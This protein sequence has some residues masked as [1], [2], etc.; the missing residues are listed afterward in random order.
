MPGFAIA[1]AKALPHA[2][3]WARY[4]DPTARARVKQILDMSGPAPIA[5]NIS[6]LESS[7]T[8]TDAPVATGVTIIMPVYNNRTM[9]MEALRRVAAHTDVPWRLILIDDASP[10]PAVRPALGTFAKTHD[11]KVH[12]VL[13]DTNKGFVGTV[14][15]GLARARA[16]EDPVVILNTDAFVPDRWATRLLRPIWTDRTVASVTPLS[17]DAELGCVPAISQPMEISKEL[18][19]RLDDHA[20]QIEGGPDWITA[21]AGV[22]FCMALAPQF[23]REIP[24]F[25]AVFAPGYGEEVDWCQKGARKGGKHVYLPSLF[26]AH[27]GGQ[28]FGSEAKQR[29][30]ARNSDILSRRYPRFD[31]EVFGFVRRD[32]LVTV[33]VFLGL[34]WAVDA[35]QG[36]ALPI[37]IGHSMGGGA[38]IDLRR[39]IQGDFETHQAVVVLRFGGTFRFTLELWWPGLEQPV[40]AGTDD[41]SDIVAMLTP[42]KNRHVI[43]SNAVGD[44][45][46]IEVAGFVLDV[47]G[48]ADGRLDVLIHDFFVVSPSVTLLGQGD[49]FRWPLD[50]ADGRH[51]S[52]RAKGG[53]VT[54][55]EW[56][57][58]WRSLLIRADKI[59]CFSLASVGIIKG[60]YPDLTSVVCEP[61]TLPVAVPQTPSR[62]RRPTIGVLGNMSPQK[63]AHF[64]AELSRAVQMDDTVDLVLL[65][66]M[67]PGFELDKE[68]LQHG[69]YEV[70]NLPE[71]VAQYG[72][73]CWLIPSIWPETFSFTTHE[74]IATGLPVLVFDLGAQADAVRQS[75]AQGGLG[76]VL[77]HRHEMTKAIETCIRAAQDFGTTGSI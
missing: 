17:N 48:G 14:N 74:A 20:R 36:A 10:D 21:P 75:V 71:L 49:V 1:G 51:Q 58:H 61:H 29:L 67:D 68:T 52:R 5:L 22:G 16:W 27:M 4:R 24:Q 41:W 8:P 43:Y 11:D 42:V 33:R 39:R 38:E 40:A 13:Q 15:E 54:L 56:Q 30:I 37:Y 28:S 44:V 55:A 25:D 60:A 66:N 2:L 63:G 18:A 7:Q 73:T 9:T 12:L 46:P 26:V 65:G 47:L 57:D 62:G 34:A 45:D 53:V 23:L 19:D 35:G 50:A 76:H 70:V 32:P 77:D 6:L 69:P 59:L 64:V 3:R 72:I 31:A